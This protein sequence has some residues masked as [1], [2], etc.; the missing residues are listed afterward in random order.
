AMSVLGSAPLLLLYLLAQRYFL[1]GLT[2]G[3]VTN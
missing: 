2:A 3:S 1:A